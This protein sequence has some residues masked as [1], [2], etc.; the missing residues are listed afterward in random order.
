M[1]R[2]LHW[3]EWLLWAVEVGLLMLIWVRS[4]VPAQ[5]QLMGFMLLVNLVKFTIIWDGQSDYSYA[6]YYMQVLEDL[7]IASAALGTCYYVY[8]RYRAILIWFGPITMAIPAFF[9]VLLKRQVSS[10]EPSQLL[11]TVAVGGSFLIVGLCL[12]LHVN[13]ATHCWGFL[14]FLACLLA[15]A[16]LHLRYGYSTLGRL[17][18]EIGQVAG[19]M[20]LG[21]TWVLGRV[22]T[23]GGWPTEADPRFKG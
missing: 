4:W 12:L 2:F 16:Q 17:G 21:W 11:A 10:L 8:P 3:Y 19:L 14:W 1:F 15:G 6:S 20:C 5:R 18:P 22:V 13:S 23:N 7:L 9:V